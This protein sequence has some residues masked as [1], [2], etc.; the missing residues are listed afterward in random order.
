MPR[1]LHSA[2][3]EE[4]ERGCRAP[5]R[6]KGVIPTTKAARRHVEWRMGRRAKSSSFTERASCCLGPQS[7]FGTRPLLVSVSV[8][9]LKGACFAAPDSAAAS[10]CHLVFFLMNVIKKLN[11]E[12]VVTHRKTLTGR[13]ITFTL[14]VAG[15]SLFFSFYMK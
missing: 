5:A 6:M 11:S 13:F 1:A 9:T 14:P 3:E 15:T 7:E 10:R 4:R 8:V 2:N 12:V